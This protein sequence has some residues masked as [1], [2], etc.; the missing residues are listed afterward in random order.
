M[1]YAGMSKGDTNSLFD[2]RPSGAYVFRPNGTDATPIATQATL[3]VQT[4]SHYP[5]ESWIGTAS[6]A[7]FFLN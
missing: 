1:W 6:V 7:K 3:L 5:T 2:D 4:G